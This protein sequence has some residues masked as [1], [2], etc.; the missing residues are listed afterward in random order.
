MPP[1]LVGRLLDHVGVPAPLFCALYICG[2]TAG[3]SAHVL[4]VQ[5]RRLAN[6]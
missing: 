5:R 1:E 2:R 4:D 6:R 3:W